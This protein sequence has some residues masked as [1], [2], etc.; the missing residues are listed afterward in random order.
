MYG[1]ARRPY[2]T[3]RRI[4]K[5][6]LEKEERVA[7][8]SKKSS[9]YY[10]VRTGD[11]WGTEYIQG[12]GTNQGCKDALAMITNR[13]REFPLNGGKSKDEESRNAQVTR[14]QSQIPSRVWKR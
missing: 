2:E 13:I 8:N 6:Q 9:G 11:L 10:F 3:T 14:Y 7:T 4:L 1:T 12:V 5:Q